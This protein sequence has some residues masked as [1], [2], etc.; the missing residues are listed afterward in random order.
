[1]LAACL[2]LSGPSAAQ[3]GGCGYAHLKPK[4]GATERPPLAVGDSV[5]IGAAPQLRAAGIEVEARCARRPRE[6]LNLL[7]R[8]RRRGTLPRAVILGLGTNIPLSGEDIA[9]ARRIVGPRRALILV[10]PLRS[11]QPFF[12]GR[13]RRAARRHTSVSLVDWAKAARGRGDWLWGDR[14]HLRPEGA[15]AYARLIRRNVFRRGRFG[16]P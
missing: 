3:A 15:E 2:L 8:R 16:G 7:T 14:T 13:M 5:M 11:G 12:A 1:M 4:R 6:G 10:T 9:R